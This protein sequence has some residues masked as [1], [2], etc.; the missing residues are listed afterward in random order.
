M[1]EFAC[2]QAISGYL[3]EDHYDRPLTWE[4][5]LATRLASDETGSPTTI[6]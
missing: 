3:I 2:L 4:R 1:V 5:F 6:D